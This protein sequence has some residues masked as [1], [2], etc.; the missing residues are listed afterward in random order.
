MDIKKACLFACVIL[1]TACSSISIK[2]PPVY[3]YHHVK[4][5]ENIYAI[6]EKYNISVSELIKLNNLP[7][8]KITGMVLKVPTTKKL[9]VQTRENQANLRKVSLKKYAKYIKKMKWPANEREITSIFGFRTSTVHEGI[10]LAAPIGTDVY[11]SHTGK[12]VYSGSDMRGYG[13]AIV[14]Q[15]EDIMTVY[16]HNSK[17]IV[18]Q[19]D[20]V[21]QGDLIAKIGNSG[22]SSGPHLHFEIRIKN[23]AGKFIAVDPMAFFNG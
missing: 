10:D 16:G 15:N 5:G 6:S 1:F 4:K 2:S 12:V 7:S 21:K 19:G 9:S 18:D 23:K 22:I 13:N 14:I 8:G 17:L 11:A 20:V 3:Y